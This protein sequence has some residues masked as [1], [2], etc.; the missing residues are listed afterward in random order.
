[1]TSS[2]KSYR[3]TTKQDCL[4]LNQVLGSKGL[5]NRV[6][7]ETKDGRWEEIARDL[8]AVLSERSKDGIAPNA[9]ALR[10]HLGELKKKHN[11]QLAKEAKLSGMQTG[12]RCSSSLLIV[13]E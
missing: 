3:Y 6:P 11:A 2:T 5:F 12:F 4:L 13:L 1:V 7:R 10:R 8:A 9:A